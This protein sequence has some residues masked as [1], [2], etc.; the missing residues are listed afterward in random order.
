MLKVL[1]FHL[2]I[3]TQLEIRTDD[4]GIPVSSN[5]LFHF[6]SIWK[7]F[8]D[9]LKAINDEGM[10][11]ATA[12]HE[13]ETLHPLLNRFLSNSRLRTSVQLGGAGQQ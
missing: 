8:S 3:F 13:G 9:Q 2:R 6:F 11:V 10:N 12:F 4:G 5:G 7:V 1:K